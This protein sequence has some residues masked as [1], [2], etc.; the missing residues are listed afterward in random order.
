MLKI[1][2]LTRNYVTRGREPV[3]ALKSVSLTVEPGEIFSLLGP[4]GCGKTTM[5]QC[6]AGL[7]TPD[8]GSIHI[9]N[10][11]VF[12]SRDSV[13]TPANER[14]LGMVFQS[15]AIWPHMTVAENVAFPLQQRGQRFS[16]AEIEQKVSDALAM[17]KLQEYADRPAPQLSGG[18]Q[19]RVALA[20]SLV[21]KPRLLLLDEP[22]S[23]LDAKL[24]DSMRVELKQLINTLG[25]TA[26]F[27]THDQT[28]AMGMSDRV[29]L[30][31]DGNIVQVG[32]PRDIYLRPHTAS[33]AD[34]MGSG[35]LVRCSIVSKE[36]DCVTV[37][38]PFGHVRSLVADG[39][40]P[41]DAGLLIIRP[42]AVLVHQVEVAPAS[43]T[44][45]VLK[46]VVQSAT[47]LGNHI[48]L[49]VT[50]ENQARIMVATMPYRTI[51]VG[52]VVH[53]E[54]PMQQCVVVHDDMGIL[55][56]Q[57]VIAPSSALQPDN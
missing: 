52:E 38:T 16:R 27:V 24:R 21:H 14:G 3:R 56:K 45:A 22:L 36:Q 44:G 57:Q 32:S 35:N 33:V 1:H 50:V 6:I 49:E 54:L 7:E 48:E 39:L 28:E 13:L 53:L 19:Q 37:S 25:I 8:A 41:R 20:R 31:R 26:L 12:S 10:Q 23:N 4:S 2:E 46:G 42:N 55:V 9:D 29:A 30:M 47:F 40:Q 51:N 15:Y 43:D 34:F 5:L 17:V 18:Q 11:A